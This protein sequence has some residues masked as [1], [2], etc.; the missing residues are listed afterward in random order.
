MPQMSYAMAAPSAAYR[1]A[2]PKMAMKD[3]A[4][5]MPERKSLKCSMPVERSMRM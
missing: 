1:S 3:C 2:A 4:M 5:M